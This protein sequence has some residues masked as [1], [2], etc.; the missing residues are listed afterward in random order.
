MQMRA[1]YMISKVQFRQSVFFHCFV[2]FKGFLKICETPVIADGGKH[3]VCLFVNV[4][5]WQ[6]KS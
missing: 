6:N 1:L 4:L 3:F 5:V 2:V